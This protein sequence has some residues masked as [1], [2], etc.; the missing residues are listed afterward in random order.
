VEQRLNLKKTGWRSS[1]KE[2]RRSDLSL[3][4]REPS[5]SRGKKPTVDCSTKCRLDPR[6][7]S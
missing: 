3:L 1:K 7:D 4:L 5:L 2:G 6:L